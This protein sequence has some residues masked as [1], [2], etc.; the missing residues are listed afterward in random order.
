MEAQD[1]RS[2]PM[3]HVPRVDPPT[4]PTSREGEQV[5]G[6][7]EVIE[8][9]GEGNYAV[10]YRGRDATLGRTVALKIL[11]PQ[12]A[13]D[14]TFVSR[15]ER[16]AR[17]AASV[18]HPN[19]V[20]V[21]DYGAHEGTFFIAMQYVA[22]EDLKYALQARGRLPFAEAVQVTRQILLG[23]G[24]IHSAG[25]IHR[26][27]KPQ[28]ILV[29]RD[30]VIRVTDFGIAHQAVE[31]A[32]T[33]HGTTVGTASYM[34]PEQARGGAL[35]E[36]T[37]LYAV[38]VVLFELVTGRLPFEASNPMAVMLAHLQKPAPSPSAVV[39]DVEVPP[40]GEAVVMRAL[41]KAPGDRYL[42]AA[43]MMRDLDA[44]VG[45]TQ[46]ATAALA[47]SEAYADPDATTH[48]PAVAPALGAG[49]ATQSLG[50]TGAPRFSRPDTAQPLPAAP[51]QAPVSPPQRRRR[52]FGWL[53]PLI[54]FGIA[55]ATLGGVLAANLGGTGNGSDGDRDPSTGVP[56][57]I[58]ASPTATEIVLDLGPLPTPTP[59]PTLPPPTRAPTATET[60]VP[61]PTPSPT[62]V[63]PTNTPIPPT[64]TPVPPPSP[65]ATPRPAPTATP[66]P[67]ATAIPPTPE[68]TAVPVEVDPPIVPASGGANS[69]SGI[70]QVIEPRDEDDAAPVESE[71]GGQT[72]PASQWRGDTTPVQASMYGRPAVAVY[73][74]QSA[75]LTFDLNSVPAGGARLGITGLDDEYGPVQI[76]VDIN[77]EAGTTGQL[78]QDWNGDWDK[79]TWSSAEFDVPADALR[80]G[81]NTV[82]LRNLQQDPGQ[83]FLIDETRLE[84]EV[85]ST[86]PVSFTSASRDDV[87]RGPGSGRDKKDNDNNGRGGGK[88]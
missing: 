71:G 26:D 65:T 16:E 32:L 69:N 68:P 41:E 75:T 44:A 47:I 15:F 43:E 40:E 23:L 38:G 22:G 35:S 10:T 24:A 70:A 78:F 4:S 1:P 67:T 46:G 73:G 7:Y 86:R 2:E 76:A 6:R 61:S 31:T 62:S 25:I 81:T 59:T 49:G 84:T 79:I 14:P 63:P 29:G 33:S 48:L 72:F 34:A 8:R 74:G 28:N 55:L 36:A 3:A 5:G 11:R 27:I 64:S 87:S 17:V 20:D 58:A 56:A 9:I 60:A 53:A 82:T 51:V 54:F 37:D 77:G 50:A 85:A 45:A 19:I 88:D 42:T 66:R 83:Y 80:E 21:Y 12:Y 52:D 57:L 30:G 13:S 18:S 39:P